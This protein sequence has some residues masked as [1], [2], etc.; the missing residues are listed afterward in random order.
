MICVLGMLA[1]CFASLD[2]AHG[3]TPPPTNNIGPVTITHLTLTNADPISA[4]SYHTD[5]NHNYIVEFRD[6]FGDVCTRWQPMPAAPHNYGIVFTTNAGPQRFF[7][8]RLI[9]QPRGD[10]FA[11]LA[12]DTGTNEYDGLT[13]DPVISGMALSFPAGTPLRASLDDTNRPFVTLTNLGAP[14]HFTLNSNDL[15]RVNGGSLPDGPHTLYL[16]ADAPGDQREFAVSFTLDTTPPNLSLRLADGFDS[17]PLGDSRTTLN[18]VNLTGHTEPQLVVELLPSG[19]KAVADTNGIFTFTSITLADGTNVFALRSQDAACNESTLL[20]PICWY[21]TDCTFPDTLAGWTVAVS[22]ARPVF[23]SLLNPVPGSV[24]ADT[25]KSCSAL[26]TEGDSFQVVLERTFQIPAVASMLCVTYGSPAFDSSATSAMRDAFEIA[27]VDDS[28]RPLTFTIQGGDGIQPAS[29]SVP[30]TLPP[31]PDAC[32]NHTDGKAPFTAP[33]VA[34]VAA[35]DSRFQVAVD[36][37]P[38]PA[39]SVAKLILR[40]VNNDRDRAST[41]RI[42]D[43]RFKPLDPMLNLSGSPDTAL[44]LIV[45]PGLSGVAPGT[46]TNVPCPPHFGSPATGPKIVYGSRATVITNPAPSAAAGL[47]TN[48]NDSRI[49]QGASVGTFAQLYFGSDTPATRQLVVDSQFLS[50]NRFD[51]TNSFPATLLPTPWALAAGAGGCRGESHDLTGSG[52]YSYDCRGDLNLFI[53]ANE[54]DNLWFQ[55]SGSIGD[56]VFDLGAPSFKAAV[57]NTIDHG[58]L[59]QE[60]IES[61]V[62]LSADRTNW[63][64]AVVQHVWL[65]GWYP[66]L[67]VLWDGFVFAVGTSN[68]T[69]FRYASIIHGGPSALQ[70]DGDDEI[71]GV[72]GLDEDFTPVQRIV[73]NSPTL[74]LLTP[75]DNA[76]LAPGTALFTGYANADRPDIFGIAATNSVL[77]VT[78]NGVPVDVL[79]AAGNFFAMLQIAPGQNIIQVVATDAFNQHTTNTVTV[80]GTTCPDNFSSLGE[81]SASVQPDYGRTSFNEWTHVLYADLALRNAATFP[82]RDPFYVGVTRI[83]DATVRL[84]S[85]DGVSTDGVPYYDFTSTLVTGSLNPGALSTPR[86]LAFHNPNKVQFTYELVVLGRLNQSPSITTAPRLEAIVGHPYAY[87]ADAVDPDGDF[88]AFSLTVAPAFLSIDA[89]TGLLAGT[90][91]TNDLGTH[92]VTLAVSDGRGGVASQH[93]LLTV[94]TPPAN[95]PPYFVST[96]TAEAHVGSNYG[97]DANALDDDADPLIYSLVTAPTNMTIG[98]GS[99][100]F[101]WL[102]L[103]E[104]VGTHSVSVLVQDGRGGSN[105]Q[106]YLVCV[107]PAEGNRSPIIVSCPITNLVAEASTT[108]TLGFDD[109][110]SIPNQPGTFV[111]NV[112]RLSE[113]YLCNYGAVFS[114]ESGVPAVAVVHLLDNGPNHTHSNPNGIGGLRT[115]GTLD[116]GIPVRV[117]LR[118]LSD[119]QLPAVTDF[120][121][122]AIDKFGAGGTVSLEGYDIE[123]RLVGRDTKL[124]DGGPILEVHGQGIHTARILGTA[125]TGLDDFRFNRTQQYTYRVRAVDPDGGSLRFQLVEGP[126]GMSLN[127]TTGVLVWG[128]TP[129]EMSYHDVRIR[130]SDD[131]GGFDEQVFSIHVLANGSAAIV[132]SVLSA[133]LPV[134]SEPAQSNLVLNGGFELGNTG[135]V[136]QLIFPGAGLGASAYD[137]GPDPGAL[138]PVFVHMGDHTTGNGMMMIV[139][140]STTAGHV[141]WEQSIPV[142]PGFAYDFSLWGASTTHL[143]TAILRVSI[144]GVQLGQLLQL[145]TQVGVWTPYSAS[146]ESTTNTVARITVQNDELS[147]SGNDFA[148][149]DFSF[150]GNPGTSILLLTGN[151]GAN[152]VGPQLVAAGFDLILKPFGPDS[153][154]GTLA[155]NSAVGQ[156][157]VWNDGNYGNT[158]TPADPARSFS[159]ADLQALTTFNSRHPHWVMDSM[160]WRTHGPTDEANLTRNIAINLR[161][162]GG[163]IVLGTD[164][165]SGE[166]LVQHVNQI[167][168]HF[169]FDLWNGV[170]DTRSGQLYGRGLLVSSPNIVTPTPLWTYT[171]AEVPNGRQPN[172]RFLS[173]AVFGANIAS[174]GF[175]SLPLGP[176]T[177]EGVRYE[178]V[179][180]L[181]TTTIPGGG[182]D[183]GMEATN[184]MVYAQNFENGVQSLSEWSDPMIEQTPLGGRN[185][186]GQFGSEIVTLTLSNLPRHST[187]NLAFDL[188]VIQSWD[189]NGEGCC[190]ESWRLALDNNSS[191]FETTFSNTGGSGNTQT[192]PESVGSQARHPEHTGA[193]ETNSLGYSFQGDAVYRMRFSFVHTADCVRISFSGTGL[194]PILNE[195][196][197]LDN[198]QVSVGVSDNTLAGWIAYLD[199]NDN[200]QRD[201]CEPFAEMD[202]CGSYVLPNVPTGQSTVRLEPRTGWI[203]AQP[204]SGVHQ[205]SVTN[206]QVLSGI[207]FAVEQRT[208]STLNSSPYFVTTPPSTPL[209]SNRSLL[210]SAVALD[211]NGDPLTY[212]LVVR[213]EGMLVEPGTGVVAWRPSLAQLGVHDVILRVQDARGGVALQ[214][215]Q[216]TVTAPNSPP[217]ITSFPP[218]PAVV[219]L[220]WRYHVR[221]QD[222]DGQLLVFALGTNAPPGL[223]ITN[224]SAS[225]STASAV[226]AWTPPL[227][228]LGTNRI[229]I[230]V[231]DAAGS[232]SRQVFDLEVVLSAANRSPQFTTQPRTQT[233]LGFPYTYPFQATDPDGD[234]LAF[235]M[236]SG[237]TGMGLTNS[238]ILSWTPLPSQLGSNFVHLRVTDGR[239][240][241]NDQLFAIHVSSTLDNSAPVIVSLPPT[242]ATVGQPYEYN[243]VANDSDGDPVTWRIVQSPVGVSLDAATGALRWQPTLEQLGTHTLIVEVQD[244]LLATALQ[245]WQIDVGCLNRPPQITSIPPTRANTDTP[246]LYAVRG[247]DPDGDGMIFSF[248]DPGTIPVGMTLSNLAGASGFSGTGGALIRWTPTTNDVGQ[249]LVRIRVRDNHGGEG[250]QDY[251][252]HVIGEPANRSPYFVS[253]PVTVAQVQQ[254]NSLIELNFDSLARMEVVGNQ[255]Q[256]D[257]VIFSHE[258]N[259]A[260]SVVDFVL[261]DEGAF[262]FGS[263]PPNAL[264]GGPGRKTTV[265][266]VVPGTTNP[267]TTDFVRLRLG[268]GDSAV[269]SGAVSI[270]GLG[271]S[272]LERQEFT[273]LAGPMDGGV[274][275]TFGTNAIASVEITGSGPS[276]F[277]YDDFTFRAFDYRV[278][279][280][281][282]PSPSTPTPTRLPTPLSLRPRA[283]L[284]IRSPA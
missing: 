122:I 201:E 22:E 74:A 84:L 219:D 78:F 251:V 123:G 73:P 3:Q 283:C 158:G 240:G 140:G 116:Y 125:T 49:W 13:F 200:H 86:A 148:L 279:Y 35:P 115:D 162:A 113:Q 11:I 124:D 149:D 34:A 48:P 29:A 257:G 194:E 176:A 163:G 179:E 121:S 25:N 277:A 83:S 259:L 77:F 31:S 180:H 266:F 239:T 255:Y 144:N 56:T 64:P 119:L 195:S 91:G 43:V 136:S 164:D 177:F 109:L 40:L 90:P 7:R 137:I 81:V 211:E 215:W 238:Q 154:A 54:I 222:S 234:P 129:S 197:G 236:V 108:N 62:Y 172:G 225:V 47:V 24:I 132:G 130:V 4:L 171:Q 76:R 206:G 221:A 79:D 192:F 143:N 26:M 263:S 253:T 52:S 146:W 65:E 161:D 103:S 23:G 185:F 203:W 173:T 18:P 16:R 92:D 188:F 226:L 182:L 160:A 102:P 8:V 254:N 237:P 246:Y 28:G 232:E 275:L 101:H 262:D 223:T 14:L 269:E 272:L 88:L 276:G 152:S 241:T 41:V 20:L 70:N 126:A 110:P 256:S 21:G 273:T 268:D 189:G 245:T 196:W 6:Q 63:T 170:Y 104:Q 19:L 216:V 183:C 139:N 212:D 69:P 1:I 220:P 186:L 131:R 274:T 53:A 213:P 249:H 151:G 30:A 133:S 178:A 58:P 5:S 265:F 67:G 243:L 61:T 97:Y 68:N 17:A 217:F 135:F 227:A 55:S 202:A 184:L 60:A 57:F 244:A 205:V 141:L 282:P 138:H 59:P 147:A 204:T 169:G 187:L 142:Q 80:F 208:N 270:F 248:A 44:S 46:P 37:S 118:N 12:N 105:T 207:N 250:T 99:G 156:I 71:N 106:S 42:A 33:G 166:A 175:G 95:R 155:T 10:L 199:Q 39:N 260:G 258:G 2:R 128:S 153:I 231:R 181:I 15:A 82:I 264:I 66:H 159:L 224:D 278:T 229:E 210:Y 214:S 267:A 209:P 32:F 134:T 228:S 120:I 191:P 230:L 45:G 168:A 94:V 50:T 280:L 111:P 150:N 174:A 271:G 117:E 89:A 75:F 72:L 233:R 87:D 127:P 100:F 51:L 112:A 114:S 193:V 198:V 242:H 9:D 235:T 252:L 190:G 284:S 96:P 165:A 93:Y 218:G 247:E 157:W 167:C 261:G 38:L 145:P 281:Y 98:S 85:P 107:L 27:L 36:V